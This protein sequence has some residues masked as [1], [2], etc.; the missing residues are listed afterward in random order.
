M[1][2]ATRA[3]L[4]A[5]AQAHLLV[6][7]VR[8][9]RAHRG[10][11]PHRE[12]EPRGR[13]RGDPEAQ[14]LGPPDVVDDAGDALQHL[15]LLGE[16]GRGQLRGA[17]RADADLAHEENAE[18][19]ISRGVEHTA[20]DIEGVQRCLPALGSA[21]EFGDA[22]ADGGDARARDLPGELQE[23]G[24]L[25]LEVGVEGAAGEPRALADR[26]DG[27][28][29]QPDFGE[30]LGGGIQQ[31]LSRGLTTTRG[32]GDDVGHRSSFRA[33]FTRCAQLRSRGRLYDTLV[34]PIQRCIHPA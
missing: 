4:L 23:E 13:G 16:I 28:R 27:C 30:H 20:D 8:H 17:Q 26:F 9:D 14:R 12:H 24:V 25:G 19:V 18:P 33:I 29:V 3:E 2:S 5:G 10:R 15:V 11:L 34:Y 6:A 31:L 21:L 22:A 32:C 7:E 1:N